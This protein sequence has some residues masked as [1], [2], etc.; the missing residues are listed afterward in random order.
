MAGSAL[1]TFRAQQE[2]AEAIHQRLQDVAVLIHRMNTSIDVLVHNA[3]YKQLLAR[4]ESWLREAQKTAAEVSA[5]R[6]REARQFWPRIG[7]WIVAAVFALA[8]AG[9]AGA[10]YA[11]ITKPYAVEISNLKTRVEFADYVER[12]VVSMT[13]SQRRQFDTLMQW[14]TPQGRSL[15]PRTK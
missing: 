12:R 6:A 1:D 7:R 2:A 11:W 5:W 14:S 10:G 4:E 3:D 15:I 8:S 9:A 13:P